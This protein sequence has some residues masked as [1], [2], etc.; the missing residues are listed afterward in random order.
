MGYELLPH[1]A[2]LMLSAWGPTTED[3]LAE[4]AR[5]LVA[6]LA[7]VREA[8]P[9][10]LVGFEIDPAPEPELLVQLLEEVIYLLDTEDVVP[11]A[12]GVALTSRGGLVG[13]FGVVPLAEV[14]VVGQAPKAVTRH[15]LR[16]E[17]DG[18]QV[19]CQV[20]IDI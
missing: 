14:P 11:A 20:V 9:H 10:R 6:S 1:T 13:E 3:C 2:D 5:A 18:D 19:R 15:G 8:R 4:A 7:D 17:R 16:W 12:V